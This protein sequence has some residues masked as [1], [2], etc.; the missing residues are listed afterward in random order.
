[1]ESL[2]QSHG[3]VFSLVVRAA[4]EIHWPVRSWGGSASGGEGGHEKDVVM[5]RF[6]LL[7]SLVLVAGCSSGSDSGDISFEHVFDMPT[8]I[9]V[10]TASGG[11]VGNDLLCAGAMGTLAGLEDEDG[12]VR[13]PEA[14]GSLY[15][16]GEP[17]VNVSV[18]ALTCNDGSGAFT[19]RL[20][21]EL[22]PTI[23]DGSPV[24]ANTWTITAGTGYDTAEGLGEGELPTE[25]RSSRIHRST[26]TITHS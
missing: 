4:A 19:L 24:A 3:Q 22:D 16:A 21:N 10:W 8:V 7:L 12:A 13:I 2:Q 25:Q 5:R 9:S 18:E 17:F 23:S 6:L 11:A 14:I 26:G 1:M 15:E 20:I